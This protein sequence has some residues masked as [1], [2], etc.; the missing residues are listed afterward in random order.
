VKRKNRSKAKIQIN[1]EKKAGERVLYNEEAGEARQKK[2]KG[3]EIPRA[4]EGHMRKEKE[5]RG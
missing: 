3:R 1:R 5:K 2:G 4:H